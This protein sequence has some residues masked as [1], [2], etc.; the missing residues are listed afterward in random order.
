[1]IKRVIVICIVLIAAVSCS[2]KK[3]NYRDGYY[4]D[5][6]HKKKGNV[7]TQK[8]FKL[9]NHQLEKDEVVASSA[10]NKEALVLADDQLL[11]PIKDQTNPLT[12]AL[13]DT[14]GD[15]ILFKSGDM[16]LGKV[17]EITDDKIK[18]K[19]CD[20]IDG[21]LFVVSKGSVQS[22]TYV[23][24]VVDV[25]V[26]PAYNPGNGNNYE[27]GRSYN[28]PQI[29]HPKAAWG[30]GLLIAGLLTFIIGIGVI[31]IVLALIFSTKAQKEIIADPKRYK[32]LT[33]AKVTRTISMVLVFALA[34]IIIL[35]IAANL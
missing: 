13:L 15:K 27:P 25:I 23:N 2:V 31:G 34:F 24:G 17:L 1:M 11:L 33:L 22:I 18:Y 9:P 6:A 8:E 20:N 26:P 5:W 16:I 32:G 28:G 14:C 7:S 12:L 3:R 30:F 35:A 4:I 19:R 10:I 29:I 21:P